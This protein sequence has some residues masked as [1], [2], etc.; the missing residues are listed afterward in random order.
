MVVSLLL[1]AAFLV[2]DANGWFKF[3]FN[4]EPAS[5]WIYT[6]V[7]V[8][9]GIVV[10]Y[11]L[12]KLRSEIEKSQGDISFTAKPSTFA[13]N[14]QLPNDLPLKKDEVSLY[15][16]VQFEIWTNIDISTSKLILNIVAFRNLHTS[17]W[18][19][20]K[21]FKVKRLVG[22]PMEGS[23]NSTYSKKIRCADEQP[24]KDKATFKWR[25]KIDDIKWGVDHMPELAL[26]LKIPKRIL[27]VYLDDPLLQKRGSVSPL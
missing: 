20:W 5:G 25:G 11:R 16:I 17:N 4:N 6:L 23:D 7:F 10:I 12:A 9:F 14:Y 19:S 26:E 24:F 15:T 8:A 13:V 18:K 3:L 27:R 1:G 22:I 2:G 21:P